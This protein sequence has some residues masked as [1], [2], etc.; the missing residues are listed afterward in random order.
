VT[1]QNVEVV[2]EQFAATNERDFRRAMS[3]YA[4]DVVLV[5]DRGAF[6]QG[7][8][9]TG[10]DAVGRWFGDWL[11]TFEPGYRFEIEETRDLGDR[12]FL[13]AA[14]RGRGRAS[15]AEVHGQTGYLYSVRGGKIVR[16]EL[17]GS[18]DAAL[19]AAGADEGS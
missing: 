6:L 18:G 13:V 9:F 12:V 19:G 1:Q 5:V 10:R 11:G 3:F 2:H 15:G 14:H 8:T 16:V 4:E 17:Y 7:G